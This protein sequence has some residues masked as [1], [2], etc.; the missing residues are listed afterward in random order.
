ML[1]SRKTSPAMW[2][3]SIPERSAMRNAAE[4][5]AKKESAV[6]KIRHIGSLAT[7]LLKIHAQAMTAT[8][9]TK[10][11]RI[12]SLLIGNSSATI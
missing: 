6:S 3:P 12:Y 1:I 2:K 8:A 7:D 5:S 10:D 4:R 11:N 9:T